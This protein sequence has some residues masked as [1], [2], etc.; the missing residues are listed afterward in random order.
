LLPGQHVV[1]AWPQGAQ[2]ELDEVP[3]HTRPSLRQ[4][5]SVLVP[6]PPQ[7]GVP[8]AVPHTW[9]WPPVEADEHLVPG[10]VQPRVD[11]PQHGMPGPPQVPQTLPAHVPA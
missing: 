10:A 8:A 6:M 3:L 9:H 11:V 7:Q 5:S 1:P 4:A 2:V